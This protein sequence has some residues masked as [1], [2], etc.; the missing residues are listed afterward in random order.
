[1]DIYI[2]RKANNGIIVSIGDHIKQNIV[3][4]VDMNYFD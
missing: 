3:D 2:Y 4:Y 1:M